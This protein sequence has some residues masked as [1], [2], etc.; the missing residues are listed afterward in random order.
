MEIELSSND[1]S[2]SSL[3][4]SPRKDKNEDIVSDNEESKA[5]I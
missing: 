4:S 5:G 2:D 1:S 3:P